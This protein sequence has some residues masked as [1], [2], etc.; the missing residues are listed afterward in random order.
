MLDRII[1]V[2]VF[3]AKKIISDALI[4][5]FKFELGLVYRE[6]DHCFIHKWLLLTDPRYP[7]GGVKVGD[8]HT[9]IH[10]HCTYTHTC[11]RHWHTHTLTL[12]LYGV[13]F[14]PLTLCIQGY[15]KLSIQV[16]GPGDEPKHSPSLTE[17]HHQNIDIES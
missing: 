2:K 8:V 11:T 10:T 6:E 3:N 4:G 15:L 17:V 9:H 5:S 12:V 14:V 7:A 13:T 1:E 16:L